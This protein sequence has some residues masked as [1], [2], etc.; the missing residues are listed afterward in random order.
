MRG[1]DFLDR[2]IGELIAPEAQVLPPPA[3]GVRDWPVDPAG[4]EALITWGLPVVGD[5][6]L[7]PDPSPGPFGDGMYRLATEWGAVVAV[8]AGSGRVVRLGVTDP[9][10]MPVNSS[11][12]AFVESAWRYLWLYGQESGHYDDETDDVLDAF[13]ARLRKLDP[14]IGDDP[15]ASYWPSIVERW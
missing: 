9:Q 15:S 2:P 14:A 5:G 12:A 11:L 6:N 13:L 3:A 1:T 4:R 10:P 7:V 8:Q